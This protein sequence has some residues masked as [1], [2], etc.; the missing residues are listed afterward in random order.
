MSG[1][2]WPRRS[3]FRH[4]TSDFAPSRR[5]FLV[6]SVMSVLRGH[7]RRRCDCLLPLQCPRRPRPALLLRVSDCYR[8]NQPAAP[9]AARPPPL[10]HLPP[11]V[12]W[13]R[14]TAAG[15]MTHHNQLARRPPASRSTCFAI[16]AASA[17]A[18]CFDAASTYLCRCDSG[19]DEATAS[20]AAEAAGQ[21]LFRHGGC[22]RV[23]FLLRRGLGV[24]PD[25]SLCAA[26]PHKGAACA[27]QNQP[28][29]QWHPVIVNRF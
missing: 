28:S 8:V 17:S 18:S 26:G 27:L 22:Q 21:H 13:R 24:N 5:S 6:Y 4:V 3:H 19:N 20:A 10:T 14:R 7:P 29:W 9:L 11:A 16:V 1:K 2:V 15:E 23:C 12:K 25:H